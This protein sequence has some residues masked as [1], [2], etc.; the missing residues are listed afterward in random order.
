MVAAVCLMRRLSP[1]MMGAL[2][3]PRREYIVLV[4]PTVGTQKVR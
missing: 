4:A 3:L 2:A 1:L